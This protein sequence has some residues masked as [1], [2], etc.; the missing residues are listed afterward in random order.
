[1]RGGSRS[2]VS[3]GFSLSMRQ[4]ISHGPSSRNA[5]SISSSN[6]PS[7][8][9][10]ALCDARTSR[11]GDD[12]GAKFGRRDLPAGDL[13]GAVV[14]DH[15]R[16]VLLPAPRD[17]GERAKLHQDRTVALQRDHAALRLRQRDPE[18][19]RRGQAHAAQHVE[20]LRPPSRGPQVEV[21]VADAAD[22]RLVVMQ[23][24]HQALGDVEAVHHLRLLAADRMV[25][26]EC[27]VSLSQ[28]SPSALVPGLV[29]AIISRRP[30][31]RSAGARG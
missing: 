15:D 30:C 26:C 5:S 4:P 1:M 20:I 12:I 16:K 24:R 18:R 2:V 7:S 21:G 29:P 28:W 3:A 6:A 11:E 17:G 23:P 31:P 9:P 27:H 25:G 14:H 22:H 13:I 19:D 8:A 10:G